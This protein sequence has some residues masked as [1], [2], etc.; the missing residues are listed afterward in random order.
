[1]IRERPVVRRLTAVIE[2]SVGRPHAT[3][4][5]VAT[6]RSM[7]TVFCAL[8]LFLASSACGDDD[9]DTTPDLPVLQ[10]VLEELDGAILSV[11]GHDTTDLFA[12]GGQPPIEPDTELSEIILW[13]DGQAWHRMQVD[14]P[15][16]WWTFGLSHDDV[17]AVGELATI[18][19]FDGD[20]WSTVQTGDPYTL[21]GIWGAASDDIWTCGGTFLPSTHAALRHW[22]GSVWTD[23]AGVDT[24]GRVFFKAWGTGGDDVWIVG[25]DHGVGLTLHWD[26]AAWTPIEVPAPERLLTV[27]GRASDDVWAVGGLSASILGHWDGASWTRVDTSELYE[28]LM[29]V[30]TAPGQPV[31]LSGAFGLVAQDSVQGDVRPLEEATDL[32][33][34][35]AWG[36]GQGHLLAGGGA[37]LSPTNPRGI[38]VG[39]GSWP[40]GPVQDWP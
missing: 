3:R 28:G 38:L 40:S 27:V 26:G 7:R 13:S 14:A 17:W 36:D 18:L 9:D 20:A 11:W 34:H 22:D 39:T 10:P 31:F 1:M 2:R 16:L 21:Y 37:L 29:G 25:H 35:V 4:L 24:D 8:A 19:H 5:M 6:A 23:A 33:L 15:T 12:V 32:C 30:W